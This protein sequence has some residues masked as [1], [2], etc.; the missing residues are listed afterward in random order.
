MQRLRCFAGI[1][2]L[3]IIYRGLQRSKQQQ[4][5]VRTYWS[6]RYHSQQNVS[7]SNNRVYLNIIH[8]LQDQLHDRTMNLLI[9]TEIEK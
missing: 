4:M 6:I 5:L 2:T 9:T 3:F 7:E 1:P 8:A